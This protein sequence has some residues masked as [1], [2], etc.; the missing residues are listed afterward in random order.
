[1]LQPEGGIYMKT[2]LKKLCSVMMILAL[3]TGCMTGAVCEETGSLQDLS[4]AV[5]ADYDSLLP[6]D[7]IDLYDIIGIPEEL[8]TDFIYLTDAS[9]LEGRE[10]V[11]LCCVSEE[12][13]E[14]VYAFLSAY[15]ERRVKETQNY[16]PDA[17][18][19]LSRAVP[20][21]EGVTVIL[22]SGPSAEEETEAFLSMLS[23]RE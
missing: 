4:A 13:A 23:A 12:A 9:G 11:V 20:V 16:L 6:W 15:L 10:A 21:K 19:L 5:L 17:C 7:E 8:Y 18:E 3:W 14:E 1:M 22:I 2:V